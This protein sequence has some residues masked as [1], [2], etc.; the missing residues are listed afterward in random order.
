VGQS[1]KTGERSRLSL[2]VMAARKGNG[3]IG[4]GWKVVC[5]G[6]DEEVSCLGTARYRA[7]SS[8]IGKR[9]PKE[10]LEEVCSIVSPERGAPYRW[11][12]H[13]D[14]CGNPRHIM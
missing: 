6:R 12:Q 4:F 9:R 14:V 11:N 5:N 7:S 3:G 10:G 13:L 8:E 2:M 1:L